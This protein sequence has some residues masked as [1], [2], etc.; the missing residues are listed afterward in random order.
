MGLVAGCPQ[1]GTPEPPL[2]RM[3]L[4]D[5]RVAR[6]FDDLGEVLNETP[7]LDDL[8]L[9]PWGQVLH[10]DPDDCGDHVRRAGISTDADVPKYAGP[11]WLLARPALWTER[12][13]RRWSRAAAAQSGFPLTDF[14]LLPRSD[15]SVHS[16][17]KSAHSA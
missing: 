8:R 15:R 9:G 2:W 4:P 12:H 13:L 16:P 10:S 7:F 1:L 3:G 17:R 5:G 11:A 14:H 6:V